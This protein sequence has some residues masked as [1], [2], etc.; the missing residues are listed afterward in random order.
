MT[1]HR[2]IDPDASKMLDDQRSANEH[3]VLAAAQALKSR[4][5]AVSGK[6]IAEAATRSS[7]V[8]R[9]RAEGQ[10]DAVEVR[11]SEGELRLQHQAL[12]HLADMAELQNANRL[13]TLG[14]L[15]ASIA[16]ELGTPLAVIRARTQM[17]AAGEVP[18]NEL[19]AEAAV[20]LS[21]TER[22]A[23]MVG[24]V[25]ALARPKATIKV[26]VD[27]VALGRQTLSIM[28]PLTR[29]DRVK[30]EFVTDGAPA[31]VLGDS[32]RLLQI[33][34][35]LI[36]NAKQSTVGAGVV[37][38]TLGRRRAGA[39]GGVA[40]DYFAF[41]VADEGSGIPPEIMPRIFETFFTTKEKE[42]GTG[43]GLAVSK[44]IATEHGGF[45]GVTSEVGRG[46]RFTLYL[47]VREEAK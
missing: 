13:A 30:L 23:R 35:N 6:A 24:E 29:K 12:R 7:E 10:R 27:L 40:T 9:E 2:E 4:D 5:E 34:T 43:L 21:Q 25:L 41:D 33:L 19:A 36:L 8:A 28:A 20:I 37:S 47:P 3:L 45:I 31:M 17:I 38:L 44:R 15:T 16:H 22:M 39:P 11:A 18:A 26:P 42:E 32:S 14:R 46:S 1:K